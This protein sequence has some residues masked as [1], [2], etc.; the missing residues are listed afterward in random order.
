MNPQGTSFIPHRPTQGKIQNRGVRKV[1]ILTYVSYIVFFSTLLSV[2][3]VLAYKFTLNAQLA[4]QQQL[5]ADERGKFQQSD[6]DSVKE[7][8]RRINTSKERMN[9][10]VSV[11]SIFE[12][13]EKAAVESL[14]FSSF[15]YDR[16]TDEVPEITISGDAESFNSVLF[17]RDILLANPILAQATVSDVALSTGSSAK[18]GDTLVIDSGKKRITFG[19]NK[20]FDIPTVQYTPRIPVSEG[21]EEFNTRDMQIEGIEV[22]N[23]VNTAPVTQSQ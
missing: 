4:R 17:Q 15:T 6:I 1:Y 10:H 20:K 8:E 5:L 2:G 14:N 23:E 12:A 16:K 9:K 11:L 7:L 19:I 18:V 21:A 3:G 22:Q 13:F